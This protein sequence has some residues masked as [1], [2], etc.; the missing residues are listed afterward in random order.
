MASEEDATVEA[1][2]EAPSPAEAEERPERE[3]KT[4]RNVRAA[5][6]PPRI[7]T[8]PQAYWISVYVG[9]VISGHIH[10]IRVSRLDIY[11]RPFFV[12]AL[13]RRAAQIARVVSLVTHVLDRLRHVIWLVLIGLAQLRGP[14]QIPV[15]VRQHRG[16]LHQSLHAR[17]PIL[18]F[19]LLGQIFSLQLRVVPHHPVRLNNLR[20]IRRR[21][22]YLRHKCIGIQRNRG[23]QLIQLLWRQRRELPLIRPRWRRRHRRLRLVLVCTLILR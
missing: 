9:R 3:A 14:R 22:Q 20:W 13:L 2:S 17:I 18:L 7:E 16:K 11:I 5:E 8:G 1:P 4:E 6:S 12:H 19:R 15:Q 10:H 21:G 23:Y